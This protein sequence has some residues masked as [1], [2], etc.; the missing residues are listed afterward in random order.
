MERHLIINAD[1]FGSTEGINRGIADCHRTGVVTS[2][3]LMV[4]GAA[5][6]DA[7]TRARE[8]PNLSVGLHWVGDRSGAEVDTDDPD[9]VRDELERQLERFHDLLGRAP[10]HLDSHH[11]LHLEERLLPIFID[12]GESLGIPVRGDGVVQYVGGFYAQWEWGVTELQHV[13]V[14]ALQSILREEVG[15]GWTEVACHPGY[16][17]PDLHSIYAS[18]REAEIRTLT[19]AEIRATVDEL[20][21]SLESYARYLR[22]AQR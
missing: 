5:A 20:G 15:E 19:D 12:A 16:L 8:L 18:E 6:R 3:S 4:F 17:T 22:C 11:H 1:D 2:T 7:A 21:I 13:S 10:D 14:Q 9:A